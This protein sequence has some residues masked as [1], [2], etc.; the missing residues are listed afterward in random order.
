MGVDVRSLRGRRAVD[1]WNRVAVGDVVERMTWSFPDRLAFVGRGD[2]V[3]DPEFARVTYR[4]ADRIANQFA[5]ALAARGLQPGAVVMMLCENS[6]EAFLVKLGV[7]KAGMT[8]APV[9]PSLAPDVIATLIERVEPSLAVIDAELGGCVDAVFGQTAL[10]PSV[11]IEVGGPALPGT[12]SFAAFIAD[13]PTTEP[14]SRSTATTSGSCC[15]LRHDRLAEGGH[16]HPQRRELRRPRFR[17][18][19]DAGPADRGLNPAKGVDRQLLGELPPTPLPV[20]S[21]AVCPPSNRPSTR[22]R[23]GWSVTSASVWPTSAPPP[24]PLS[25]R[26]ARTSRPDS[27]RPPPAQPRAERPSPRL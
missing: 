5:H 24:W 23:P 3:G 17:V 10:T 4:Q 16:A 1:R 18:V 20:C 21:R 6:V 19:A 22:R 2:A 15:H 27:I 8:V 11:T 12:V 14:G 13:R 25:V 7:A 26:S 9:N